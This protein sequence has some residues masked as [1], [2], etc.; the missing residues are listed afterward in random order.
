MHFSW[1]LTIHERVRPHKIM[2]EM[3]ERFL[4]N[5]RDTTLSY[6][7]D[8]DFLKKNRAEFK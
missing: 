4:D 3:Y 8:I 2:P 5:D 1:N 7:I 6:G